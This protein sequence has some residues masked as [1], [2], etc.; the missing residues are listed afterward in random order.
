MTFYR[1]NEPAVAS[2]TID[3]EVVAINLETG[4]YF[5]L[6][7][8]AADVWKLIEDRRDADALIAAIAQRYGEAETA[9]RAAIAPFIDELLREQL[10]VADDGTPSTGAVEPMPR[11]ES[12]FAAPEL[13]KYADMQDL[14]LLDPI[15][16]VD[17]TGW[18]NMKQAGG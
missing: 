3:G 10:I 6:Q 14:L 15:H 11:A 9:A 5:S 8:T 2:E 12:P 4:N 18:P 13:K 7:N 17:E 1:K 16:E